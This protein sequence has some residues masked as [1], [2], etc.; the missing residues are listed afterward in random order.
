MKELPEGLSEAVLASQVVVTECMDIS[1]HLRDVAYVVS[2][3]GAHLLVFTNWSNAD[4]NGWHL[5]FEVG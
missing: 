5:G 3:V 1:R 2:F 4:S